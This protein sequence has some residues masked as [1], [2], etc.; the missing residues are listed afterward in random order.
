VTGFVGHGHNPAP[1][2]LDEVVAILVPTPEAKPG[3]PGKPGATARE[4]TVVDFSTGDAVTVIDGPFESFVGVV[5]DVD[6]GRSK[7]KVSV[8][9]FGRATPVELN[10]DQVLKVTS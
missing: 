3:E 5:E 9:I 4:V 6:E 1:L 10:F 7:L 8:S 2:S